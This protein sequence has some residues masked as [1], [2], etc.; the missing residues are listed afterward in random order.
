MRSSL[1]TKEELAKELA[2]VKREVAKLKQ[3]ESERR[4]VSEALRE[5]ET[6]FRKITEKSMMGV[7]L[8]QDDLF[9]YVNPKMAGIFGYEVSELVDVRGPKDVVW[10]ED[11]P[12]VNENL[13]KRIF[14]E[15]ESITYRFRGIKPTGEVVHIEVYGSRTDYRARPAVIGTLLDIT[16]RVKAE[17]KLEQSENALRHLSAQLLRAQEDERKRLAQELHDGIG[18]SISAMKFVI[19]T[20]LKQIREVPGSEIAG[21]LEML[22]PMAESTVE[23][24]Q[25]IAVDLRP[26]IIDDLGLVATLRWFMRRFQ[27]TYSGILLDNRIELEEQEI[28]ESLKIVMFR[29]TQEALN[30]VTR[31]SRAKRVHVAL[32]KRKDRIELLIKDNGEG[33]D[34]SATA[35]STGSGKG[36]GLSSM[37]ERTEFSGGK[38]RL[39]TEPGVG[40]SI[41]ASWPLKASGPSI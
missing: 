24:V 8:I 35:S 34:D 20:C 18:Q 10:A 14:G 1:Q 21:R 13:R 29:I 17:K 41:K 32:R 33:I 5:S 15:L 39:E 25:R 12:L 9:R 40:T 31:H 6:M 23:E 26:F 38:F 16:D 22:L 3:L 7:Y 27:N 2:R 36:F 19:E 11:W 37:K 4:G 28:P 30:N